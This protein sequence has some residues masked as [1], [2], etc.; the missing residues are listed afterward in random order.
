MS[1]FLDMDSNSIVLS[2]FYE[3]EVAGKYNYNAVYQR[4]KIWNIEKK[5]FLIDTILKNYPIPPIFLRM[6][7]DENT[8]ATK[9]DVIDGKQRLTTIIDFI[10]GKINL[11]DDFSIGPF[12]NENLDGL[13]F[14]ELDEF[15]DYKKR[16]WKYKIPIIYIDS[17]DDEVI[18]NVFDRLN[19]NGEPL[20]FQELRNA[21]YCET[22]FYELVEKL[23][24]I[25]FW[26][27]RLSNLEISRMEDKEFISELLFVV[28]EDNIISY[29]RKELD[30][31]YE[32]WTNKEFNKNDIIEKFRT[33]TEFIE[34]LDID[35]DKYKITGVSHLYGIWVF[36]Y[37]CVL[38]DI[39]AI[40]IKG[41]IDK[42]YSKLRNKDTSQEFIEYSKSMNSATKS[43]SS[44]RKR[45]NALLEYM[46]HNGIN[47]KN[48][49]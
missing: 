35:Y 29:T 18:R 36:S 14:K 47:I 2:E 19:R 3:N 9:Y 27:T 43:K 17:K 11:P 8:G 38:Q 46:S 34:L 31:L 5:R 20:T 40:D 32:K 23:S 25:N 30:G 41:M 21:K 42:F 4:E 48:L 12:G 6:F 39:R 7:I 44:R 15:A 24:G 13:Y 22:D 45:V 16:F 37:I 1:N 28:L 26:K 49:L 10:N 33:I